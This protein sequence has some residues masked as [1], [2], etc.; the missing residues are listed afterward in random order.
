MRRF[1][2]IVF[3]L[4][5]F[6]TLAFISLPK[7]EVAERLD[8]RPLG[9]IQTENI[10][11]LWFSP[12]RELVGT[13]QNGLQLTV[14]V[15]SGADGKILRERT[16]DLPVTKNSARPVYSVS[17]DA[18][19]AAWL[20]ATGVHT[21]SLVSSSPGTG[22]DVGFKRRVPISA[23]AFTGS[24][25]LAIVYHD[26]ELE[27]WDGDGAR[28]TASKRLDVIEPVTLLA[29]RQ[30]VAAYSS[31]S[32][33]AV[34]FDTGAGNKLSLL[35]NRKYPRD[36]LSLTLS[37]QGRLAAGTRET[38]EQ[39]GRSFSAPGPIRALAFFDRNRVLVGGDFQG[40]YL[41]GSDSG[42]EQVSMTDPG[43]T[44]LATDGTNMAFGNG[45]SLVIASGHIVQTRVYRGLSNL[46]TWVLI[47]IFA[48]IS[49]VAVYLG[50]IGVRYLL[51]KPSKLASPE[52][53]DPNKPDEGPIPNALTEACRN[54]DCVLWAG[55]GLAAQ[56]GLPTWSAFL[57]EMVEWAAKNNLAPAEVTAAAVAELSQGQTGAAA[58]RMAAAFQNSAQTLQEYL[59]QRF[60][61]HSE[62]PEAYRLIKEIDF[63]ALITTTLDNL[64][65]RTF[66][67]SGGRVYTVENCSELARSAA[68]RNF[69]LLK[70]FGDLEQPETVRIGPA[71][72]AVVFADNPAISD[73][74]EGLFRTKVFLFLGASLDGIERDLSCMLPE[75]PEGRKHYAL[76]PTTGEGWTAIADR[77]RERYGIEPLTYS[78]STAQHP[79]VVEFLT[80]LNQNIRARTFTQEDFVT[81]Q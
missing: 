76:V 6:G 52:P 68:R 46:P 17:A 57:Q 16:V 67:Y 55:S 28:I 13:G 39:Q 61:V 2:L 66:P 74:T 12:G 69:F 30:Y 1:I 51:K 35:E 43:A 36:V 50:Y 34:V 49:P 22:V 54:G 19:K 7:Y 9:N 15:W 42:Q 3:W 27:I 80:K 78:P 37:P 58:A 24:G 44:V 31:A 65:D 8:V 32:G 14:R 40:I 64:L 56:A 21:E 45:R 10:S 18:S 77:L 73:L 26:G 4:T 72:C 33:D 62:L 11:Q 63:P 5:V 59:R 23:L 20:T 81:D 75:P 79:E 70:P 41:L 25:A 48:L 38:V 47:A 71:E 60:V 29:N 53:H